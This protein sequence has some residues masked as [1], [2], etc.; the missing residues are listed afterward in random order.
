LCVMCIHALYLG[1]FLLLLAAVPDRTGT[2]GLPARRLWSGWSRFE[3][4]ADDSSFT[5]VG[6]MAA[7]QQ[8]L[9]GTGMASRFLKVEGHDE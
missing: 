4:K 7:P 9:L 8:T 5:N 1:V 3:G 2:T 6:D